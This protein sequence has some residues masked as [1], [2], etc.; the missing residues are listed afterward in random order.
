MKRILHFDINN[1]VTNIDSTDTRTLRKLANQT[2]SRNVYGKVDAKIWKVNKNQFDETNSI[3]YYQYLKIN[4]LDKSCADNFAEK[5]GIGFEFAGFLTHFEKYSYNFIFES[6]INILKIYT[7]DKIVFR[8]FGP[9]GP[10]IIK[11][12]QTEY[13]IYRKFTTCTINVVDNIYQMTVDGINNIFIGIDNINNYIINSDTDLLIVD[14]YNYWNS[15]DRNK[16]FGKPIKGV[17]NVIQIFCDDNDC[18][19]LIDQ[20]NCYIYK[21]NTLEAI[22]KP[23]YFTNIIKPIFNKYYSELSNDSDS[24]SDYDSEEDSNNST[25][26]YT[27]DSDDCDSDDS[28]F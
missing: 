9:D 6:F 8:T 18:I 23:D 25:S 21:I 19:N 5:D 3:S 24:S 22:Q 13:G 26:N 2:I 28:D 11:K 10:H 16:Q 1:T 14:D 4:N 20:L 15:H 27:K 12:L 17:K 7:N